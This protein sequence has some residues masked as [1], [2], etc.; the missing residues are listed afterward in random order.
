MQRIAFQ[1]RPIAMRTVLPFCVLFSVCGCGSEPAQ[2][3]PE[4]AATVSSPKEHTSPDQKPVFPELTEVEA[5]K[6]IEKLS[7]S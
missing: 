6:A 1:M 4:H 2:V 7:G 3:T 5:I